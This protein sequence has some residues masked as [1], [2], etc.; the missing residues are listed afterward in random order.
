MRGLTFRL[1]ARIEQGFKETKQKEAAYQRM[2]AKNKKVPIIGDRTGHVPGES[3]VRRGF[4]IVY[5]AIHRKSPP[6][7]ETDIPVISNYHCLDHGIDCPSSCPSL[8]KFEQE[9]DRLFPDKRSREMLIDV[10]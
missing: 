9:F 10:T 6:K 3:T 7:E 5:L 2:L 4:N 1:I 8:I